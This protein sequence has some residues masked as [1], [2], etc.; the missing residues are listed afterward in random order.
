MKKRKISCLIQARQTSLRFP[1]KTL[2]K[3]NT[4]YIIDLIYKRLKKSKYIDRIIFLIP[5]NKKNIKLKNLLLKKNYT[6]YEGSENNVLDRYYKASKKFNCDLIV[7]IT[8]DCPLIDYEIVDNVIKK[9]LNAKKKF[10]LTS[11]IFPPTFPDGLDVEVIETAV[12][13]SIWKKYN[14]NKKI[15]KEHVTDL[16]YKKYNKQIQNYNNE[17]NFSELRFTLDNQEDLFLIKSVYN[18]FYPNIYFNFKDIIEFYKKNPELILINIKYNRNENEQISIDRKLWNNSKKIIPSGNQFLSKNPDN[19]LINQW[20]AYYKKAKG[21]YVWSY[22]N[23]KYLDMCSMGQGTNIL[24]YANNKIDNQVIKTIRKG[25]TSV[26]NPPEENFLANKLIKMHKDLDSVRF[27]RSGGEALALAIR[28][29]RAYTN[30][31]NIAMCGYHGWH[32]W[33]LSANLKNKKNLD[34]HLF[35]D[36]K[37]KGVPKVLKNSTKVFQFN[38]VKSLKKIIENDKKI[39]AIIMEVKRFYEPKKKFLQYIEKIQKKYK[40]PLILDEC[41]SGFRETFGGLY[42][43]YKLKPDICMFGKALGNGYPI[44]ALVGKKDVME[45]IKS[46]FAS[47]T[48][49]SERIGPTAALASLKEMERTKSWNVISKKGD[50]LKKKIVKLIN[51]HKLK[52]KIGGLRSFIYIE[53]ISKNSSVIKKLYI[54]EMLKKKIL[55]STSIFISVRHTKNIMDKFLTHFEYTLLKLKNYF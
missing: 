23:K 48:F 47:S 50:Y 27:T 55:A 21:C 19:Y 29:A 8:A 35:K 12:L 15:S 25:S 49:W 46:S 20:P 41:T 45:S 6:F 52:I 14:F 31:D 22:D 43:N 18:Y 42:K 32:D 3:I 37:I 4:N 7:R 40:I 10:C 34:N 13:Y 54:K 1:N 36:L 51:K 2:Q 28:I 44:T 24:G 38:N 39:A 11:N 5:K 33:Y 9:H 16:I 53:F 30:K 26:L 17:K